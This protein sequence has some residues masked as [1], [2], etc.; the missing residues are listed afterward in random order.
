MDVAPAVGTGIVGGSACNWAVEAFG[1]V[2]QFEFK[3]DLKLSRTLRSDGAMRDA[4]DSTSSKLKHKEKRTPG[5]QT[6][7]V[8]KGKL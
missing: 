8:S 6:L 4:L 1:Y 2:S 5:F 3:M 7:N